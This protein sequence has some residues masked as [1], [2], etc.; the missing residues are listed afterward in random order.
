MLT[1]TPTLARRLFITQQ[2]LT[3]PTPP[4][5]SDSMLK[6]VRDLG[7]LQLDP[8]TVVARSHQLVMFSRLGPY[9][10]ATLDHLL[11]KERSLFEYWAHCASIV[12]TEDYDIHSVRMRGY[13]KPGGLREYTNQW[14]EKNK[15]LRRAILTQ[16]RRNGPSLAR[17]LEGTGHQAEQ[18]VST[19]WSSGRNVNQMLDYLWLAGHIMVVGRQ[20]I[21]KVWDLSD[22]HLPDWTPC[23]KLTEYEM[24]RRSVLKAL[25]A[26]G[27]GT[28][29]HIKFHF[30]R[31]RYR[32]LPS[33]LNDLEAEGLIQRVDIKDKS[34]LWP[35]VWYMLTET[36]PTLDQ[37]SNG[38]W[39]PR[40]T[41]LSPFDN[42]ICDR[43]RT[44]LFFN[45]DF[46]IEIYTPEAK[47]KYG[48][49]VLPLLHEDKLIG[50]IDPKLDRESGM[51]I[52]NAVHAEP[53]APKSA[54]PV[55]EAIESLATFLGARQINY[56]KQRVPSS[57][58]RKLL[59]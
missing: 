51:L 9:D 17:D 37:L 36:V 42:L 43:N 12:L 4:P 23:T 13:R 18:W 5:T 52:V 3:A 48:Y 27:V 53:G 55:R 28:I 14:L 32:E 6:V 15:H 54:A 8:L 11:F 38:G 33:V 41:L 46:R 24:T 7:C 31:G 39:S 1:L 16:L 20:G 50:R 56:N 25:R 57:W 44:S 30:I 58:K 40:T 10:P 59:A 45:F 26:L 19:G 49:Y 35:G 47:R 29:Q 21:Q 22:R 34:K 2:R